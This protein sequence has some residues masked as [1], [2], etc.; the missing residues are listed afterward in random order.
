[1]VSLPGADEL[2]S[3]PSH[4]WKVVYTADKIASFVMPQTAGRN[5]APSQFAVTL[6]E[7]ETSIG[8]RIDATL[9][10]QQFTENSE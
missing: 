3:V 5:D 4:F 1:M 6:Q 8:I 7:L 9:G 10:R 2:H